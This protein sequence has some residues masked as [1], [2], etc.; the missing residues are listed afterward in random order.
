MA[1]F[2]KYGVEFSDDRKTLVNC[3]RDFQG[4]Y[5]IPD[6]VEYI[7][8]YAFK[9]CRDLHSVIIPHSVS[10]ILM[11]AFEDCSQ[12]TSVV[13]PDGVTICSLAFSGCSSLTVYLPNNIRFDIAE[14]YEGRGAFECIAN[15]IYKGEITEDIQSGLGGIDG[16]RAINGYEEE[17]FIYS[18]V[19]KTKLLVCLPSAKGEV[20]IPNGVQTI[21]YCAFWHCKNVT[22]VTIPDTVTDIL[23]P[24]FVECDNLKDIEVPIGQEEHFCEM[25][26]SE[27]Q[28]D[29]WANIIRK[30]SEKLQRRTKE[31]QEQ[32]HHSFST[33]DIEAMRYYESEARF[34]EENFGV[35]IRDSIA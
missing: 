20:T 4:E 17:N 33:R 16:A 11:G 9:E 2:D 10:N 19:T 1:Y 31:K 5:I 8:I 15:I 29:E 23:K 34:I 22:K 7:G 3:P 21:G 14:E 25:I 30:T 12:L 13:L 18:D 24:I 27:M 28:G 6:G 32:Q 35:D 26:H